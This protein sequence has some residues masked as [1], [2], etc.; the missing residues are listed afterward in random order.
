MLL[1][2]Y[3][4]DLSLHIAAG[5]GIR[6]EREPF[7]STKVNLETSVNHQGSKAKVQINTISPKIGFGGGSYMMT[8]VKRMTAKSNFLKMSFKDRNCNVEEYDDCRTRRLM[9][10]CDCTPREVSGFQVISRL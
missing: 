3:N 9:T 1:L 10:A 5:T 8:S 4:E 2:D 6:K 7:N